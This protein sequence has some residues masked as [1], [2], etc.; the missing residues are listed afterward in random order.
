MTP[1]GGGATSENLR[2]LVS[3]LL[4]SALTGPI[5]CAGVS[6]ADMRPSG[7]DGTDVTTS[8]TEVEG[9]DVAPSGTDG[10]E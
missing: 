10:A 6:G 5:G 8:G 9:A 7:A 3:G 4:C 2:F 1:F